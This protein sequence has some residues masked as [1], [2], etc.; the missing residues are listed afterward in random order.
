[1]AADAATSAVAE[2]TATRI[3]GLGVAF[4][5]LAG[6]VLALIREATD[7]RIRSPEQLHQLGI[8]EQS[9]GAHRGRAD[10][11]PTG[12]VAEGYRVLRTVL[13]RGGHTQPTS[14]VVSSC[15]GDRHVPGVA[16]ALAVTFA[17]AATRVVLVSTDLRSAR[18]GPEWARA[19]PGLG[20][21]L[22]KE[23]ITRG[24]DRSGPPE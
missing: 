16:A 15:D 17:R 19:E 12:Q 9:R 18:T 2:E 14:I 11:M 8:P 10:D 1:M 7:S 24:R 6:I 4:G 5:L 23:G 13:F 20:N 21:V 22:A 3:I